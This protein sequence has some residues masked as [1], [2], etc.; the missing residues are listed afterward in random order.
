QTASEVILHVFPENVAKSVAEGEVLQVVVFS[1]MFG[2]GLAL[3]PEPKR[4]PVLA[5]VEGIAE[6]MFKFTNIVMYFAPLGVGAAIAYTVGST[7][8]GILLNLGKLLL[9][10]YV[11]LVIFVLCVLLPVAMLAR[12]PLRKFI[13]AAAEPVSIA[14]G[15][16]SSEAALPRAM[17]AMEKIGVPRQVV[18]FVM[19]TGYS[20][21]LDGS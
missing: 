7:G 6:T 17:E 16:S 4:R 5:V 12:V 1:V 20:F 13:A 11:A 3:V 14:F 15:T 2:I 9:T 8:M 18:A 21:N 10:L 19:P